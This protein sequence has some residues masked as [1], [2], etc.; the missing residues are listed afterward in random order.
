ML[1][2]GIRRGVRIDVHAHRPRDRVDR[3][4]GPGVPGQGQRRPGVDRTC[5]LHGGKAVL[6][7]DRQEPACI[8]LEVIDTQDDN[9]VLVGLNRDGIV[10]GGR[11]GSVLNPGLGLTRRSARPPGGGALDRRADVT[12]KDTFYGATALTWAVNPAM[13]RKPSHTD[14]VRVLLEHGGFSADALSDALQSAT[15]A[16]LE[17][18]MALLKTAGAKPK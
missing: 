5:R 16:K 7:L 3:R 4:P 9:L 14:V 11:V 8:V 18:V 2:V 15:R 12:I 10:Q 6:R 17:D 1:D 13:E